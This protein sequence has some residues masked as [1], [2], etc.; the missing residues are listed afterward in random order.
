MKKNG[1]LTILICFSFL[2]IIG[3]RR[4][5]DDNDTIKNTPSQIK[6]IAVTKGNLKSDAVILYL[7]GGPVSE[8]EDL[9]EMISDSKSSNFT[10]ASVHQAQTLNPDLINK[11]EI[12]FEEAKKQANTNAE[13]VDKV[14]NYYI[15]KGKKVYLFATSYGVYVAQD[16]IARYGTSKISKAL[17]AAGRLDVE[18]LF[19]TSFANGAPRFFDIDENGNMFLGPIEPI[20]ID[21]AEDKN[22]AKLSAALSHKR[23]TQLLANITNLDKI[24]YYSGLG[25]QSV[26]RL[27]MAEKDFLKSKNI[28]LIEVPGDHEEP[29]N[30]AQ[31]V[32]NEVFK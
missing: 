26:G 9:D 19:W 1:L 24:V 2:S 21:H 7:Q 13:M 30:A 27:T 14:V 25:D 12:T 31:K 32:I 20:G 16:Y 3:C 10:W 22:I 4:D 29:M 18:E 15:A 6:E 23:Y 11:G 8:L 5:D 17:L 28:Q